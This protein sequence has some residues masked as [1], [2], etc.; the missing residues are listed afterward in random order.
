M[1]YQSLKGE[2][3][4][5]FGAKYRLL[6]YVLRAHP[7][8][9]EVAF[10]VAQEPSNMLLRKVRNIADIK[11]AEFEMAAYELGVYDDIWP[12]T[13]LDEALKVA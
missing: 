2:E 7:Q 11:A 9:N 5:H 1:D 13:E 3:L 12:M 4:I 10:R 6:C 8:K